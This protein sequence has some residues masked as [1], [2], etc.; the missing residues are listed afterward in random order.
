VLLKAAKYASP[1]ADI[2]FKGGGIN[3][4]EMRVY[5][6]RVSGLPY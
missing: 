4:M 3:A 5:W 2:H 6:W 1:E